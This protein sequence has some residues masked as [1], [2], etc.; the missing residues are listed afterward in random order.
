MAMERIKR[1]EDGGRLADDGFGILKALGIGGR[2]D[3]EAEMESESL[4][5]LV[6]VSGILGDWSPAALST[7]DDGDL[8]M[9]DKRMKAFLCVCP[10]WLGCHCA[11]C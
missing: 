8:S 4:W 9:G 1:M 6:S 10:C 5:S 7:E 3:E 11:V 2:E